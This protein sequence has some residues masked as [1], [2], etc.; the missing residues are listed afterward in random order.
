LFAIDTACR[1]G[2]IRLLEWRDVDF[3][4]QVINVR[5]ETTKSTRARRIPMT[6][7]L[8]NILENHKPENAKPTAKVF[9]QRAF[10]KA[11]AKVLEMAGIEGFTFHDLRHVGTTRFIEKDFNVGLAM[12][13]VGHEQMST[14]QRY[15]NPT[16]ESLVEIMRKSEAAD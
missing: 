8:I 1:R 6:T 14:F 9:T 7:R 3:E 5:K 15:L 16:P 4:R 12:K 13:I 10:K 11:Y 2:E